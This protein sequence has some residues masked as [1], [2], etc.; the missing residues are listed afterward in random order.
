MYSFD[1]RVYQAPGC[2]R[3]LIGHRA[4]ARLRSGKE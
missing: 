3:E 1:I 2:D 4:D